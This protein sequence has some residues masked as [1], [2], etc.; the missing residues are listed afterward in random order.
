M[1]G[2][3]PRAPGSA[4]REACG[5]GL[6]SSGAAP[7]EGVGFKGAVPPIGPSACAAS[8]SNAGASGRSFPLASKGTFLA[9]PL[10]LALDV[11]IDR[12]RR[13]FD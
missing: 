2:Q 3:S 5:F 13:L 6:T 7:T 1:R 4:M 9:H 8:Q 10:D 12:G 11:L